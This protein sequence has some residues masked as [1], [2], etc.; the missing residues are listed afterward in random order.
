[1]MAFVVAIAG[2]MLPASALALKTLY[3]TGGCKQV[4]AHVVDRSQV[5][6]PLEFKRERERESKRERDRAR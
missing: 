3:R 5:Q 1:M 4:S 6:T 2:M